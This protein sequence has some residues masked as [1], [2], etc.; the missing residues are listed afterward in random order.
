VDAEDIFFVQDLHRFVMDLVAGSQYT[1]MEIRGC[2]VIRTSFHKELILGPKKVAIYLKAEFCGQSHEWKRSLGFTRLQQWSCG[3]LMNSLVR[4]DENGLQVILKEGKV[5]G[6][7]C[8]GHYE[9]EWGFPSRMNW[10][11]FWLC[12]QQSGGRGRNRSHCNW[13]M[14]VSL[15]L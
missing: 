14:T 5:G 1:W 12:L 13:E 11:I 2:A 6:Y 8:P 3:F 4:H 15:C 10:Y 9:L 7:I